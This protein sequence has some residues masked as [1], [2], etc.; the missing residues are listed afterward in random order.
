MNVRKLIEQRA[1]TK[2]TKEKAEL[3]L[4]IAAIYSEQGSHDSALVE[5]KKYLELWESK[6]DNLQCAVANR[7]LAECY[8]E[9]C[10]FTQ[11]IFHTNRYLQLS[12]LIGNKTEQQRAYVTLG[13]CFLNRVETL[14]DG[15]LIAKS[16]KSANQALL[17]SIKLIREL[18]PNLDDKNSAEMRA[19]S[20]LNLGHVQRAQRLYDAAF[21]S[22]S[23]CITLARKYSLQK[24]LFRASYQ[25]GEM[26]I[27]NIPTHAFTECCHTEFLKLMNQNET[28]KALEIVQ[29]TLSSPLSKPCVDNEAKLLYI[30]LKELLAQIYLCYGN[31]RKAMKVFRLL[32]VDSPSSSEQYRK[33]IR[34]SFRLMNL[35]NE[36]PKE[37]SNTKDY[38][39]SSRVHEK[40]GDLYSGI[41][42]QGCAVRHYRFMLGFSELAYKQYCSESG[43]A[44]NEVIEL[45]D[46]ALISVA[47]T[48]RTLGCYDQ[49]AEMYKREILWAT[50]TGLSTKDI[51]TSW[52]SLAQ[53]QRLISITDSCTVS[54][55]KNIEADQ[56]II[57]NGSA[58]A[59]D[60]L[61]SAYKASKLTGSMSLI[62]DCLKEL[63]DYYE[64]YNYR[65][66]SQKTR[67]ELEQIKQTCDAQSDH[68]EED[69]EQKDE[70]EVGD[71]DKNTSSISDD[72]TGVTK[73]LETLSSDSELEQCIG[74]SELMD[75][76]QDTMKGK[77]SGKA[78][79]LKTNMKG[80]T[81]LHVAAINGDMNHVVKLIEVL[82]HP[83]NVPD[84][85]GWLPIHEA[86]FHDRS[87]I[88]TYL[89]DHGAKI[90]D[91]GYPDDYS[92]PLFEA[93]H[94]GALTTA[95]IFVNRGANLWHK[96]KQ[97][98]YL[99]NLLDQWEPTRHAS[100]TFAEQRAKF[101]ELL[102]AIR[103]RLGA[104]YDS[105]CNLKRETPEN[106]SSDDSES[107]VAI[108]NNTSNQ[109]SYS[110]H[111]CSGSRSSSLCE[112]WDSVPPVSSKTKFNRKSLRSRNW[113]D[114][115]VDLDQDENSQP[116]SPVKLKKS[117]N[118][119]ESYKQ[120]MKA[121]GS[122]KTRFV[123][124]CESSGNT[125]SMDLA[126]RRKKSHV[127]D[128]ND[129]DWLILDE[130]PKGSRSVSSTTVKEHFDALNVKRGKCTATASSKNR[131]RQE[132]LEFLPH[133]AFTSTQNDN[134]SSFPPGPSSSVVGGSHKHL[135]PKS[136]STPIKCNKQ[137]NHS[138]KES[139][140]S[141]KDGSVN[142]NN[143]LPPATVNNDQLKLPK[144][145]TN[146]FP[147][148]TSYSVKVAFSDISVLVP[149]DSM[150]RSVSW[151]ATEA[152]RRRQILLGFNSNIPITESGEQ[153]V[154]LCTRDRALLLPS[155]RLF[156]IIP[157]LSQSGS[158]VELLAELNE[159]VVTQ[160]TPTNPSNQHIQSHLNYESKSNKLPQ[161]TVSPFLHSVID[162]AR[163]T[164]VVDLSN[165]SLEDIECCKLL[166]QLFRDGGIRVIT[167]VKL[168]G[169]S[170]TTD[171]IDTKQFSSMNC[172]NLTDYLCQLSLHLVKLNLSMNLF[173]EQFFSRFLCSLSK[174]FKEDKGSDVLMPR[175]LYLNLSYNPLLGCNM[176]QDNLENTNLLEYDLSTNH[177][178]C[179]MRFIET[180]LKVFPKL[181]YLNLTGC[182]LGGTNTMN[183]NYQN[184]QMFR[185][186]STDSFVSCLSELDLSWNPQ[187][188]PNQLN[189]LLSMNCLKALKCLRLRGCSTF[190]N[191]STNKQCPIN[192]PVSTLEV[193]SL[194]WLNNNSSEVFM[195]NLEKFNTFKESSFG[196]QLL[197]S[198]CSAL[199]KGNIRLQ[200]LDM[201][202]CQLTYHCLTSLKSL[203]G[204][205]GISIT[206]LI[207]D[208]NPMLRNV[209]VSNN[210]PFPSWIQIL[211]AIAQPASTVVSL[212]I[213]LPEIPDNDSDALTTAFNSVEAKLLPTISSTP[214]QELVIIYNEVRINDDWTVENFSNHNNKSMKS[215]FLFMLS[216]LFTK[217]FG[218]M[219][220]ITKKKF[221]VTF[222]IL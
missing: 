168:Q 125:D 71:S 213:D 104:D 26:L 108:K 142:T 160:K 58:T 165:L 12:L 170:L 101:S 73:F 218:K 47:E 65:D 9:M 10:D 4:T 94:N 172:I 7:Y 159:S 155:D 124:K 1:K 23:Q 103:S 35:L 196:D 81:P 76:F 116:S 24:I 87:E 17:N 45:V 123:D 190:Q 177:N 193:S 98:E 148:T 38:I 212:T 110:R 82:G 184:E 53:A 32:K 55:D 42:L 161:D 63:L 174:R 68:Q 52:L 167:E 143:C 84:G 112:T 216:N 204:T 176:K 37:V 28:K 54:N 131:S 157:V 150:S 153:L 219:I 138:F 29:T 175:L 137:L 129:N 105:W 126:K 203:F 34:T 215:R 221:S 56:K 86:A 185:S 180:I 195:K 93:I 44:P 149:V 208:H 144:L 19:V 13:R 30:N 115:M 48:Y 197:N 183:V 18:S 46:A 57:L 187:I 145:P 14:K 200:I 62:A 178:N 89:L 217:R 107:S 152:Y 118:A 88:A 90:D 61:L 59:L 222:S 192:L 182:S 141:G 33:M 41:D 181:N 166:G 158:V 173:N 49:C 16:L 111:P 188:S 36:I 151:L 60:S 202:H 75:E 205:P 127:I 95:L 194:S 21:E 50:S 96:N 140:H 74:S 6:E 130:K 179:W 72:E 207:I 27:N 201:G 91:T 106:H 211:Q 99:S 209:V 85:A 136:T 169:N 135:P 11:A 25:A 210:C 79:C 122:S 2:V 15:S 119:V 39:V 154:R 220:K 134:L 164:G 5:Y 66:K 162:K 22:F 109:K 156:S 199:I 189:Y 3:T 171:I 121:I 51:A 113:D 139:S 100:G 20:L 120:A 128:A 78:L 191:I 206:T 83:V 133:M 92:T 67:Q 186:L 117:V 69:N 146:E 77:K 198:I 31:S 114:L 8:I 70:E 97:G 214:L 147:E 163:N 102:A 132:D 64:Q 43:V 80:E 40:L